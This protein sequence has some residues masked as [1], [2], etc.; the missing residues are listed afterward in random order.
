M[1]LAAERRGRL[2]ETY[3]AWS[4]RARGFR[5]LARRFRSSAGEID[6]IARRR[7]V[8]VFAE[9]K[10]RPDLDRA[11]AA[12]GP[13]QRRRCLRAA[14]HFLALN[15]VHQGCVLRFDLIAVRPWRLPYHLADAWGAD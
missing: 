4:F 5:I 6:L 14:E 1:S 12:I 2:A 8:L 11:L 15:P 3:A 9:V 13:K 7:T 10:A